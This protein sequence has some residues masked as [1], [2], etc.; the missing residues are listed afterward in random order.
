MG[1]SN[2]S[3]AHRAA[4]S[5]GLEV[6]PGATFSGSCRSSPAHSLTGSERHRLLRQPPI[7]LVRPI[8]AS[9]SRRATASPA[10]ISFQKNIPEFSEQSSIWSFAMATLHLAVNQRSYT[11]GVEPLEFRLKNLKDERLRAVF[12]AAAKKI[13]L[14]RA[15]DRTRPGLWNG[16]WLRKTRRHCHLRCSHR[17]SQVG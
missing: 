8:P 13:W 3:C 4:K 17:G 12:E 14:G 5:D 11:D 2:P 16:R 15:Q 7:P 10:G 6:R 1:L 9:R